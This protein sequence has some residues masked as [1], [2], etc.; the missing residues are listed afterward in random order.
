MEQLIILKSLALQPCS[1]LLLCVHSN[2]SFQRRR[3]TDFCLLLF[4][5]VMPEPRRELLQHRG[6]WSVTNDQGH[7]SPSSQ[8]IWPRTWTP[9]DSK[10]WFCTRQWPPRGQWPAGTT[11]VEGRK[12]SLGG[13]PPSREQRPSKGYEI[14]VSIT[15]LLQINTGKEIHPARPEEEA[16][17]L[18]SFE[19]GPKSRIWS[20][21]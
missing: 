11:F 14:C 9:T 4:I 18:A 12:S 1:F 13:S 7:P 10:Y 2:L 3:R 21:R 17:D 15:I 16:K 19:L 20:C 6:A 8:P 5:W